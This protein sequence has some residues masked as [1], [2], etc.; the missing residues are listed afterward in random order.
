MLVSSWQIPWPWE[1]WFIAVEKN[2]SS[3][4]NCNAVILYPLLFS[5]KIMECLKISVASKFLQKYCTHNMQ[6][7]SSII[8][9][10]YSDLASEGND[11]GSTKSI[12][13]C[14]RIIFIR[15]CVHKMV[16]KN[17]THYEGANC[18]LIVAVINASV[19]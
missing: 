2:S 11:I 1:N 3:L 9:M 7:Y 16:G 8:T 12:C 18:N 4:S 6:L 15:Q 19:C 14:S 13:S 17:T 5:I 10:T